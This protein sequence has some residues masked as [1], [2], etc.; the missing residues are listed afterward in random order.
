MPY[1]KA[2]RSRERMELE[3]AQQEIL[4]QP[5]ADYTESDYNS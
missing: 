2:I 3:S 4:E 5:D 1:Q